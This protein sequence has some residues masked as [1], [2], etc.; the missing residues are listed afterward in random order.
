MRLLLALAV[1]AA[2][3][4]FSAVNAIRPERKRFDLHP[5][6]SSHAERVVF[7]SLL[8]KTQS[9]KVSEQTSEIRSRCFKPCLQTDRETGNQVA[10]ALYNARNVPR[11]LCFV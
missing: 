11:A 9:V 8:S 6:P 4:A 10:I 7:Q 5:T 2:V 3:F 1:L